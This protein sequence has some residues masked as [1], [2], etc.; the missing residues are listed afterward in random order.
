M[1]D[2]GAWLV[3]RQEMPHLVGVQEGKLQGTMN[4]CTQTTSRVCQ[5][6]FRECDGA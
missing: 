6:S 2:L 3:A 5:T 1:F 4:W